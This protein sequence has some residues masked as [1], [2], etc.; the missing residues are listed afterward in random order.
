MTKRIVTILG[1]RP[2]F[3]K[4]AAVSR[5]IATRGSSLEEFIIHTGQHYDRNMSDLFF[6]ELSIPRPY[7]NLAV[8]SGSHGAQTADMLRLIEQDL[9]QLAP[10]VVLVYG[11]TNSTLAGALAAA[12]LNIPIAHVEAGLRSFNKRMPEEIN[13]I[14]A[15]HVSTMLFAPTDTAVENLRAEG[16]GPDKVFKTGDV[17]YDVMQYYRAHAEKRSTILRDLKL[18]SKPYLLTTVHRAE[19]TDDPARMKAILKVLGVTAER[20]TVVFP[21]HPRTRSLITAESKELPRQLI[22]TDPVGYLDMIALLKHCSLVITDSGG[23]QKE[24]FFNEKF[25]LTLRPETEWT[26]LVTSGYNFLIDPL[27]SLPATVDRVV[28]KKFVK[29]DF[30]PYGDGNAAARIVDLINDKV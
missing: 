25:C 4:A 11:D 21:V 23:L 9:V 27:E 17:M 15:D 14:V 30:Q 12:K 3:I 8:G 26:E 20:Y 16:M 29:N 28:A 18:S 22:F 24:A 13:R 7:K 2:Q 19:N 6:E 10:Q 1:A 5:V